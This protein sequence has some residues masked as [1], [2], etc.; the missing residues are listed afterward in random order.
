MKS[1]QFT[2]LE[3][4]P[5]CSLRLILVGL[6]AVVVEN[7]KTVAKPLQLRAQLRDLDRSE[8]E[9]LLLTLLSKAESASE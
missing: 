1:E 6:A 2:L 4:E 5:I 8:L 7:G 9:Q 3:K